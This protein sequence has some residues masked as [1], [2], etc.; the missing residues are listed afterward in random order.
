MRLGIEPCLACQLGPLGSDP[1]RVAP[2]R[3]IELLGGLAH[4][5]REASDVGV[6]QQRGERL[7]NVC[8]HGRARSEQLAG[9]PDCRRGVLRAVVGEQ[10]DPGSSSHA[11]EAMGGSCAPASAHVRWRGPWK[12]LRVAPR[13]GPAR[14]PRAA[15]ARPARAVVGSLCGICRRC[16]AA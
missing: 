15:P 14:T 5:S 6:E 13:Q 9:P 8:D 2:V 4:A 1:F 7:S 3:L 16:G 11:G 12:L 10:R